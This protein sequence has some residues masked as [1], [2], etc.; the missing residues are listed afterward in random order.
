MWYR[1]AAAALA[2]V[3]AIAGCG[4]LETTAVSYDRLMYGNLTT[5]TVTGVNLDKGV[6]LITSACPT[7]QQLTGGT[8][9][10]QTFTCT[11]TST[12]SVTISVIGGNVVLHKAEAN[13]PVPQV[14]IKTSMGDLLLE[15]DPVKAP[16]TSLNFMR[17]VNN[18]YYNNLIFHRVI[19]NFVIQG[20]GYDA[21]MV[22]P[23]TLAPI[24][25]ESGNGLTNLRGTLAMAR[26]G[27][28]DSAT[29]Q[30]YV[31]VVDNPSLDKS[32]TNGDGYAVLG[33]VISGMDT[34]D[35]IAAVPTATTAS[36]VADVPVTP[37]VMTSVTQTQ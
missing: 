15:L 34:V 21:N 32:D 25:L 11:V 4:G 26:L 29:S 17:Y 18:S 24:K 35:A 31:N 20:G 7:P 3:A 22:G 13:I 9:T 14:T 12:G 36:G 30:F 27:T 8:A 23:N 5:F 19:A 6:S 10:Q 37:V 2:I 33:K 28:P 1:R 16:I